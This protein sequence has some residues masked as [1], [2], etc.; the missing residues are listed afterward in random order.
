MKKVLIWMLVLT[1]I[2]SM[3][4][5]FSLS[6]CKKE[7]TTAE[8]TAAATAAE[9][10][11]AAKSFN[12]G[13]VSIWNVDWYAYLGNAMDMIAKKYDSTIYRIRNWLRPG[14]KDDAGI[15]WK[16]AI[17]GISDMETEIKHL[18]NAS[19]PRSR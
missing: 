6:G 7:I 12:I 15:I 19:Y 2:M 1:V 3:L 10:T 4:V 5:V 17:T 9:T 8:T 14:D 11:A 16:L 18:K 13:H